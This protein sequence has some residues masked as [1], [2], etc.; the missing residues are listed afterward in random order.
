[1]KTRT[2]TEMQQLIQLESN[3]KKINKFE[4]T[5]KSK[6]N[7]NNRSNGIHSYV[8]NSLEQTADLNW[9][10]RWKMSWIIQ[11]RNHFWTFYHNLYFLM[12]STFCGHLKF[13]FRSYQISFT[14]IYVGKETKLKWLKFGILPKICL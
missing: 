7:W 6:K 11:N 2:Y 3:A 10:F 5:R 13:F 14:L 9:L 12:I 8:K 4:C 1:M